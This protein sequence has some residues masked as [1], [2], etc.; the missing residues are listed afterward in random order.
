MIAAPRAS[1]R[2]AGG[3]VLL[4]IGSVGLIGFLTGQLDRWLAFLFTPPGSASTSATAAPATAPP[5]SSST[6][7]RST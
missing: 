2:S 4:L 7:A 3:L 6:Y 5:A 1:D